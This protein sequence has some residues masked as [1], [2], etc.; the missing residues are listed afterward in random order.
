MTVTETAPLLNPNSV[1][2]AY[3]MENAVLKNLPYAET[4]VLTA[5]LA[6]PGFNGDIASPGGIVSENPVE[7]GS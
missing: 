5:L 1:E 3:T 4:D 6:M 7:W 2:E